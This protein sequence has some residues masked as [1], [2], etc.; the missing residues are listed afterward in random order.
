MRSVRAAAAAILLAFASATLAHADCKLL[1]I[2]EFQLDPAFSR[3]VVDGSIDGKPIK[4][5]FDTGASFSNIDRAAAEQMHLPL[6]E[7]MLRSYGIGGDEAV[8][9]ATV[10]QLKI[11]AL[12]KPKM[13]LLVAGDRHHPMPFTIT[14]GDDFFAQATV[15]FDLAHHAVRL[16]KPEGCAPAQLVYWGAAYSQ[17]DLLPTDHE[18]PAIQVSA[19]LNDKRVLATLDSGAQIT[20]IDSGVAAGVGV[21]RVEGA[22]PGK[23]EGMGPQIESSWTGAFDS[24]AIGDEKIAN[25]KL[26]VTAFRSGMSYSETGSHT[27]HALRDTP[28]M[29][30]GADFLLAHRV[31]VDPKDHLVLFSYV[32]G[33]VF[34]QPRSQ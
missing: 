11:G 8:Y 6:D 25:V 24:F 20:I 5:L 34:A 30:V 21:K 28:A 12:L 32:G 23:L 16:F 27:P 13:E 4:V 22:A 1:E 18:E 10:K 9:Q 7:T 3:P 19:F 2:A 29:F 31:I 17:A 26:Q 14:L 15:E 33:P